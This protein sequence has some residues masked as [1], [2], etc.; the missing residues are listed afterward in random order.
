MIDFLKKKYEAA[1][2]TPSDFDMRLFFSDMASSARA[3]RT[4]YDALAEVDTT[5]KVL[6]K[7][8]KEICASILEGETLAESMSRY[9]FFQPYV[10]ASVAAA[11]R[12][13]TFEVSFQRIA[14]FIQQMRIVHK[15]LAAE[16]VKFLGMSLLL[17]FTLYV[18][19]TS[20][21]PKIEAMY[22]SRKA[23]MV[24]KSKVVVSVLHFVND[25]WILFFLVLLGVLAVI[26]YIKESQPEVYDEMLLKI[27]IFSTI[28]INLIHYRFTSSIS[29]FLKSGLSTIESF[30]WAAKVVGNTVF[31]R[32]FSK[33]S[34]LIREEGLSV[35]EA[36]KVANTGGWLKPLVISRIHSG[37]LRGD[38]VPELD[39]CS[40]RYIEG[41]E[42]STEKGATTLNFIFLGVTG[43]IIFFLVVAM[44]TPQMDLFNTIGR[45]ATMR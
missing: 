45:K 43:C 24:G 4:T 28:Y 44:M 8:S 15:K 12:A 13:G 16:I 26:Q 11:E 36:L 9:S 7:T 10:I 40:E 31:G 18:V 33:T 32:I 25:H 35:A 14:Q 1:F 34:L 42:S 6:M 39:L 38:L 29:L 2:C 23:V 41:I 5:D 17:S 3:G 37:E 27:P 19:I 20:L 22:A 21:I 30:E